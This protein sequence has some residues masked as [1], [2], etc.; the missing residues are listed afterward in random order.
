MAR[1]AKW[2][3]L[4]V[5]CA[6]AG[7]CGS[8]AA[9]QVFKVGGD[10]DCPY[11]S[12]Q[13]AVDAAAATPGADYV[14]IAMNGSYA[15]ENVQVS[16]ADGVI[17]VGGLVDCDDIDVDTRMTTVSGAGNDGS[18]VFTIRGHSSVKL[19]NLLITGAARDGDAN[20]GAV[21]FDG[22]GDLEIE[23]SSITQNSAG[24]GAGVNAK[25]DGGHLDV[26][27]EDNT[28]VLGNTAQ[29]SGGGVRVEGDTRL[30]VDD[31]EIMIGFNHALTGIGGGVEV[32]GP[33]EAEIG[34]S[35]YNGG[36][37]IQF[38]DAV[39][40]GGIAAAASESNDTAHV[41]L[42]TTD[43]ANPVQV[44][45]NFASA[46]GGG[47]YLKP[48]TDTLDFGLAMFEAADFRIN[49]NIALEGSA[50][51]GDEDYNIIAGYVGSDVILNSTESPALGVPC[52]PGVPCNE[53]RGNIAEDANANPT[54]GATILMQSCS[55][56]YATRTLFSGNRGGYL[57]RAFGDQGAHVDLRQSVAA[58]NTVAHDLINFA[59]TSQ[60]STVTLHGST[61]VDNTIG[62]DYVVYADAESSEITDSIIDQLG[63]QTIAYTGSLTAAYVLTNN[64]STL[65]GG[66]AIVD[67]EPDYVDRANGDYH[68]QRSS[69]GVDFAPAEEGVDRDGNPRTVDL[70]DLPNGPGPLDLG[71][72]EI[73]NQIASCAV[74]DTIYCDG[75]DGA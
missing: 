49:D 8:A 59:P 50:I 35:G 15:G 34:S 53:I 46:T 6:L 73:Q 10:A 67:G 69:F 33:A 32:I 39:H 26:V 4:P 61:I 22:S 43:P 16:D 29:T 57:I 27:L 3:I 30:Y 5:S 58:Q 60:F 45:D 21:D 25:G 42:F 66:T 23:L 63:T 24:Y 62:S 7:A 9:F 40:G 41:Y 36:A 12:I 52:A 55:A 17:I 71:A 31:P 18:A 14:W 70:I 47:I 38:N 68:L 72:Y 37:V 28:L 64:A 2:L 48:H 75:F 13:A 51:Y 44:S 65:A 1:A 11:P 74:G 20:G 54:D 56:I 19:Q